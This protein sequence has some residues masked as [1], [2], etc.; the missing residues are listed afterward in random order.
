MKRFCWTL[1]LSLSVLC[2]ASA[3]QLGGPEATIKKFYRALEKGNLDEAVSLLSGR[4]TKTLGEE[5][6]KTGLAEAA[7]EMQQKGGVKSLEVTQ[8]NV[9][10]EI[11]DAQVK[12]EY[13]NG[14]I[15]TEKVK[16]I[17]EEG[18]WKIDVDK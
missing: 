16:L 4:I 15:D 11:A 8:M 9:T 6:I 7:R 10:G 5:K 17:K 13:G 2:L 12:L 1:C 3:C 18:R 14:S